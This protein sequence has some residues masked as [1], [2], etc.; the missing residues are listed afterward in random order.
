L[1]SSKNPL[2]KQEIV[3]IISLWTVLDEIRTTFMEELLKIINVCQILCSS[4]GSFI[5]LEVL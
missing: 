1:Q 3:D 2:P 4:N 5:L